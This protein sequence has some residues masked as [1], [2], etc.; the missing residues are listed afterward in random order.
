MIGL[1]EMFVEQ[2]NKLKNDILDWRC[3]TELSVVIE[4]FYSCSNTVAIGYW[5]LEMWLV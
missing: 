2:M 1:P 3:P 4:M 5:A